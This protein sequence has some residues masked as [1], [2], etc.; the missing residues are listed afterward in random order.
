M[1]LFQYKIH[2]NNDPII[3]RNTNTL[4]AIKYH[5]QLGVENQEQQETEKKILGRHLIYLGSKIHINY[6]QFLNK[7]GF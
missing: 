6:F 4:F 1:N 3:N 2:Q 5:P 7:C